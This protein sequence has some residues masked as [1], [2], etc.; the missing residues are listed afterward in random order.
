M[1]RH[2]AE[3]HHSAP[4]LL[5][6]LFG[7]AAMCCCQGVSEQ[8]QCLAFRPV[9]TLA[10]FRT[11]RVVFQAAASPLSFPRVLS[12]VDGECYLCHIRE[13]RR[14]E[15]IL[16]AEMPYVRVIRVDSHLVSQVMRLKWGI[17]MFP[18]LVLVYE[19]RVHKLAPDYPIDPSTVVGFVSKI[20]GMAPHNT[21]HIWRG[22]DDMVPPPDWEDA[23]SPESPVGRRSGRGG[24]G[25]SHISLQ[26]WRL[27]SGVPVNYVMM[28]WGSVAVVLKCVWKSQRPSEAVN[29]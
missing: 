27:V 22:W 17:T 2:G 18:L 25:M 7:L 9:E 11:P 1:H 16:A 19:G 5:Y 10:A 24:N 3:Q 12:I 8:E 13:Y 26:L 28:V 20:T 21:T 6:V 14:M 15:M 4:G 29:A 23:D